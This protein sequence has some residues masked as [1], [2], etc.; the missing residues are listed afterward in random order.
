MFSTTGVNKGIQHRECCSKYCFSLLKHH[1]SA[2]I[3]DSPWRHSRRLFAQHP[4]PVT[5]GSQQSITRRCF[6]LC[7]KRCSG[8][9]TLALSKPFLWCWKDIQVAVNIQRICS[10]TQIHANMLWPIT[11]PRRMFTKE[12]QTK[13]GA[14][15]IS[16]RRHC[17]WSYL[18]IF[19]C[20]EKKLCCNCCLQSSIINA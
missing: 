14:Y 9:S 7:Y 11:F 13:K 10:A 19:I 15:E 8:I 6:T 2:L 16:K 5:R 18:V 4:F 20:L 17:W 1:T 3:K 12:L